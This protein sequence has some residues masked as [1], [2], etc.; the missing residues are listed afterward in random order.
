LIEKAK[1]RPVR[2]PGLH[3]PASERDWDLDVDLKGRDPTA[4]SEGP[5]LA[6]DKSLVQSLRAAI[7]SYQ[8]EKQIICA[9][10]LSSPSD[11]AVGSLAVGPKT[12]TTPNRE[13]FP[14]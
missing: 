4:R 1:T 12:K 2:G 8:A 10:D 11:W 7:T 13:V 9:K 14:A 3:K 5:V 6:N